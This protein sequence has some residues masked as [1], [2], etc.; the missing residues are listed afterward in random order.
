MK[1]F[2][3]YQTIKTRNKL[4]KYL[5]HQQIDKAKWDECI[6]H[7]LNTLIYGYSWYLDE[8]APNWDALVLDDYEAVFPLTHAKKYLINYLYQPFFTQQLGLFYKNLLGAEH[9]EDFIK[10]ISKKFRFIDIA[11]NEANHFEV[12]NTFLNKKKNYVLDLEKPYS[13]TT[14]KFTDHTSRNIKKSKK[15]V[16]KIVEQN[17]DDVIKLYIKN[18]SEQTLKVT[19]KDYKRF[20]KIL[21][22]IQKNEILNCVGVINEKN[23]I[24]ASAIFAVCNNRITYLMGVS[25]KE[26]REKRAMYFLFDHIIEQFSEQSFLLDFE[27]SDIP[28]VANFFKGFG[29]IK[30][31]YYKLHVNNLPWYI[32]WIKK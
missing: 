20:S 17:F 28:G 8:A 15:V 31:S 16:N 19:A 7:S 26:G 4:I 14:K 18:K 22:A 32:K 5:T 9:L 25:T 29:A 24:I 13:K 3:N 6:E 30:Q 23:E 10:A 27:G 2:T 11:L 1:V 12:E 21:N